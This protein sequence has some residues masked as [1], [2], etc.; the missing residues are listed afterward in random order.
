M[1]MECV[2]L[3]AVHTNKHDSKSA[4]WSYR[5]SPL[6]SR[7]ELSPVAARRCRCRCRCLPLCGLR[8]DET[9]KP[10]RTFWNSRRDRFTFSPNR[11]PMSLRMRRPGSL[12]R[13]MMKLTCCGTSAN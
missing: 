9:H 1:A 5:L 7:R 2:L 13:C 4:W 10:S 8:T 11:Y 6:A 3:C 12:E